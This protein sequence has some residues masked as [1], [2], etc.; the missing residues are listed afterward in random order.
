MVGWH[1]QL[2]EHESGQTLGANMSSHAL[3]YKVVCMSGVRCHTRASP[4]DGCAFVY[5]TALSRLQ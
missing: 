5:S 2:N 1:H 3:S 4:T